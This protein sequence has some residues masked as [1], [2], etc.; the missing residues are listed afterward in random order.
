MF[1]IIIFFHY[2]SVSFLKKLQCLIQ[3]DPVGVQSGSGQVPIRV[4]SRSSWGLV[5]VCSGS[6]LGPDRI[7]LGLVEGPPRVQSESGGQG[8]VGV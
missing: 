5:E 8:P 1:L 2:N 7:Q 3:S 6:T 4:W